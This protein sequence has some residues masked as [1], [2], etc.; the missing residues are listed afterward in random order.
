M[1]S[2]PSPPLRFRTCVPAGCVVPLS[3]D[4]DRVTAL[5]K[6]TAL[7]IKIS[8]ADTSQGVSFTISLKGFA[9]ALDRIKALAGS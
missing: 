3:F 4:S 5:G 8:S 1:T 2:R 7:K 9:A 6:G